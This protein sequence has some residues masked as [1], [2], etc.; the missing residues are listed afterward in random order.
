MADSLAH[1]Y[2]LPER[3]LVIPNGRTLRQS[4]GAFRKPQAVTA[5]RLWDEAK[6]VAMLAEVDSPIPL[7]VAGDVQNGPE[8]A[9]STV[10][11]VTLL[12]SLASEELLRVFRESAMY[13]CPSRYEPFGLAPLE[14]ALCGCAVLANDIP[15][16]REVWADSALYF[17]EPASLTVLL[18]RLY[19]APAELAAAQRRSFE[20]AQSYTSARM[21]G[22]YH[23]LFQQWRSRE[24]AAVCRTASA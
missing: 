14:A 20:R 7:L 16:L 8:R 3:P 10:R 23:H 9:P 2:S 15:S 22:A 13:I 21:G 11:G 5:G 4:T 12:G 6:N 18:R 24:E 19:E 1:D 17:D